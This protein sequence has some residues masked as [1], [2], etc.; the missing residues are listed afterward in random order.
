ME[1]ETYEENEVGEACVDDRNEL[2]RIAEEL[3]AKGQL[4]ILD[5][6]ETFPYRKMTI[7][8]KRVY[9]TLFPQHTNFIEFSESI[10]PIRIMQVAAHAIKYPEA[11]YLKV[12][13]SRSFQDPILVGQ[14]SEY[15]DDQHILAR[16][17]DALES[18]NVLKK[19]AI[20]I[21]RPKMIASLSDIKARL[22]GWENA[23]DHH[24]ENYLNGEASY[25]HPQYFE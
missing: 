19:K 14:S 25:A 1:I 17:G 3:G 9:G 7:I 15:S 16:W 23:G 8:E 20:E 11:C 4:K 18:L 2:L 12:W 10:I 6:T 5:N 21:L 13:H 24:L 22:S